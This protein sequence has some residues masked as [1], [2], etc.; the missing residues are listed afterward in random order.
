MAF[1]LFFTECYILLWY[2]VHRATTLGPGTTFGLAF[3]CLSL[4]I[5]S[6]SSYFT[7]TRK[8][9]GITSGF[10]CILQ[11]VCTVKKKMHFCPLAVIHILCLI[12]PMKESGTWQCTVS[13]RSSCCSH[14]RMYCEIV[15][16][17]ARLCSNVTMTRLC[18]LTY[19]TIHRTMHL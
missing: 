4:L 17:L 13:V 3:L 11:Y 16:M 19:S 10:K 15:K 1:F 6:H 12:V 5:L 14:S 2:I 7:K 18:T 8:V 9:C